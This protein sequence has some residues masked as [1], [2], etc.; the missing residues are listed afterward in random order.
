[1]APPVVTPLPGTP[2]PSEPPRRA[3]R[4]PR[5]VWALA[6]LAVLAVLATRAPGLGAP[7]VLVFDEVYYADQA[8]DVARTG[9]S[10]THAVHPPLGSWVIAAGIRAVG[11]TPWGWRLGV[12]AA[13]AI[14]AG[15]T[16]IGA[17]R[18][19]RSRA[20]AALAGLVVVTDGV[21]FT[22]GRLALLDGPFALWVTAALVVLL[23]AAARPLDA[24]FHRRATWVVAVLLGAACATKW[25]GAPAVVAAIV[26]L[27][28][29]ARQAC[30][31][32]PMRQDALA[33]TFAV[34]VLVPLAI[35]AAALVPTYLRY[36]DS[37]VARAVCEPGA[38]CPTSAVGR[39]T[40]LVQDQLDLVRFHRSLE[41]RN[42]YAAS[43]LWWVV[44]G[45]GT[46]LVTARCPGADPVCATSDDLGVRRIVAVGSPLVW[47]AG[48]AALAAQAWRALRRRDLVAATLVVWVG[49]LWLPWVVGGRPGYAF[50]GVVVVPALAVALARTIGAWRPPVRRTGAAVLAA[51]A[52]GG[53]AVLYPVWTAR[54]TSPSYLSWLLPE[55]PAPLTG[56]AGESGQSSS[57][58]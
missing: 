21:A 7:D 4:L 3:R 39:F 29:L 30:P 31:P 52:I 20:M 6:G 18:A 17:Y 19:T 46:G 56:P 58:S 38:P 12:L 55:A 16:V 22:A 44:Q 26:I 42:R 54:P 24:P 23:H 5:D 53:A 35:G 15:L 47:I 14:L 34:L 1:M 28:L 50:Y 10:A 41:P 43:A 32:G 11:F 37:G 8:L 25:T 33:R 57:G 36:P 27:M 13:G 45:R 40:G 49:A 2:A 48:F 51:A 9:V